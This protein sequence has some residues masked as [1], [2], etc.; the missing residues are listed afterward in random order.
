[1]IEII[2]KEFLESK[3]SVPV[4]TEIPKKL[5][6]SRYVVIEKTGGT[7]TDYIKQATMTVQSYGP[8]MQLAAE[9]NETVKDWMLDGVNGLITEKDVS[10]VDLN[11]D[12]NYTDTTTKTYRYQAVFSITHY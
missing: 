1:M 5:D 4:L 2:V 8:S 6:A 12:Y 3:L 10:N 7:Q 11:S 9:L